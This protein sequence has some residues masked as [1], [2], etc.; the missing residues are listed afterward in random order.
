MVIDY[1]ERRQVSKN[2]SKKQPVKLITL[3]ITTVVLGIYSLGV[4]SGWFLYKVVKKN[5]TTRAAAPTVEPKK[6]KNENSSSGAVQNQNPGNAKTSDPPLT[7]YQTLPKGEIVTLGTGLNPSLNNK[8][9][10]P[11]NAPPKVAGAKPRTQTEQQ[12]EQFQKITNMEKDSGA[13]PTPSGT[14]KPAERSVKKNAAAS[15]SANKT[16]ASK[17]EENTKKKYIVQVA[18][19]NLKKEAE[20]IKSSLD[21]K[22]LPAYVVESKIPGK[23]VRYRVRLGNGLDRET[24]GKIASK[25][26][27]GAIVVPE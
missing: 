9:G 20:E 21:R 19:C 8:P 13:E 6:K 1:S 14:K 7:F 16:S 25:A 2:R 15:E 27:G 10:S 4:V 17:D 5:P 23:G 22:G 3:F 12:K 24:A 11:V 18:S 26:G